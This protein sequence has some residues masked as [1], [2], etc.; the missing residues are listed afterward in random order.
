[1]SSRNPLNGVGF[2]RTVAMRRFPVIIKIEKV[3]FLQ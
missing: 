1:M 2:L 3:T